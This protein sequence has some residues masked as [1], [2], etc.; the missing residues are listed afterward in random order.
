MTSS[1]SR[2]RRKKLCNCLVSFA[3]N[4]LFSD[5]ELPSGRLLTN[6][7]LI[8]FFQTAI[9][10]NIDGGLPRIPDLLQKAL[11]DGHR[12]SYWYS[13]HIVRMLGAQSS[14]ESFLKAHPPNLHIEK[15]YVSKIDRLQPHVLESFLLKVEN[16]IAS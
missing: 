13:T 11:K 16:S 12:L 4:S 2:T 6:M 7:W 15:K 3:Q 10:L 9:R 5:V 1:W 8:F 14:I